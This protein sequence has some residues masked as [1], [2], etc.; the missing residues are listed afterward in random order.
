[1]TIATQIH[2]VIFYPF[3]TTKKASS[4]SSSIK[5]KPQRWESQSLCS[6]REKS[7]VVAEGVGGDLFELDYEQ[8]TCS[9]YYLLS[10][11]CIH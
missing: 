1:M 4:V 10:K 7:M 2:S 6:A 5:K 9:L 3:E 8:T 11:D